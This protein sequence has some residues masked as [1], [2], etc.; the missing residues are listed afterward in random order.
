MAQ[1]LQFHDWLWP[2]QLFKASGHVCGELEI[3][4]VLNKHRYVWSSSWFIR[5]FTEKRTQQVKFVGDVQSHDLQMIYSYSRFAWTWTYIDHQVLCF[6]AKHEV[7]YRLTITCKHQRNNSGSCNSYSLT[8]LERTI[9][10]PAH[11]C[12]IMLVD[13]YREKKLKKKTFHLCAY[14]ECTIGQL[15]G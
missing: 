4:M 14:M 8:W 11:G 10:Q 6:E 9:L 2:V 7:R 1:V 12:Q 5:M 15:V 3:D 13:V